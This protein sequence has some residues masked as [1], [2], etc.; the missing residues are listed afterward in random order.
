MNCFSNKNKDGEKGNADRNV[1]G[2]LVL[3]SEGHQYSFFL[4]KQGRKTLRQQITFVKLI[5]EIP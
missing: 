4:A 2:V 3:G 5:S 1:K